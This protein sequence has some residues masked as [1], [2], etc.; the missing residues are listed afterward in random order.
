MHSIYNEININDVIMKINDLLPQSLSLIDRFNIISQDNN[1]EYL[2][3]LLN[4]CNHNDVDFLGQLELRKNIFDYHVGSKKIN[5]CEYHV[6]WLLSRNLIW[7]DY[8]DYYKSVGAY[9]LVNVGVHYDFHKEQPLKSIEF[10][11][12]ANDIMNDIND[13]PRTRAT[14]YFQTC[15]TYI[16]MANLEMAK[17][18]LKL[19]EKIIKTKLKSIYPNSME[20]NRI[21]F[22]R[23]KIYMLEYKYEQALIS[24]NKLIEKEQT[25]D[26]VIGSDTMLCKAEILN[27][28]GEYNEALAIVDKLTSHNPIFQ[29]RIL[30]EKIK[31]YQALNKESRNLIQELRLIIKDQPEPVKN[32]YGQ[33][34]ME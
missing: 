24:I 13:Y 6:Q 9:Y 20:S 5:E 17:E 11:L 18:N 3:E 27:C 26:Q 15:L 25:S 10:Y 21:W 7:N 23:A 32:K 16:R 2:M 22:L 33:F 28:L 30:T 19:F 1:E 31:T 8:S 12:M 14:I 4:F 34:I 29:I